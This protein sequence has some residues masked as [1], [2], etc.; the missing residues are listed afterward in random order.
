MNEVGIPDEWRC[1]P[2]ESLVAGTGPYTAALGFILGTV[3]IPFDRLHADPEPNS[4]DEYTFYH[5]LRPTLEQVHL[6]HA[7]SFPKLAFRLQFHQRLAQA[8][9]RSLLLILDREW[10]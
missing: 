7:I 9:R 1:A 10:P 6:N 4:G 5:F 8:L 2:P 3:D